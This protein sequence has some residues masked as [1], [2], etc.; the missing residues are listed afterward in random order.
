V[1]YN[2]RGTKT[3][4]KSSDI[5][6]LLPSIPILALIPR[7]SDDESAPFWPTAQTALAELQDRELQASIRRHYKYL[8]GAA[9]A[10]ER[11]EKFFRAKDV[12][13]EQDAKRK[14]YR[15]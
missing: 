9:E 6:R 14:W 4:R 8:T 2:K 5:C 7:V 11:S 15:R 12:V 13:A 3:I 1:P 10:M